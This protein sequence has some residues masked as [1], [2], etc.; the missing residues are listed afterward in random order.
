MK[1]SNKILLGIILALIFIIGCGVVGFVNSKK[2]NTTTANIKQ[3]TKAVAKT[4]TNPKVKAQQKTTKDTTKNDTSDDNFSKTP[5][6]SQS[7]LDFLQ[8]VNDMSSEGARV[9]GEKYAEYL[10]NSNSGG[11]PGNSIFVLENNRSGA[12]DGGVLLTKN[13]D[14]TVT[15]TI[16]D[17]AGSAPI[18]KAV[19]DSKTYKVISQ[20]EIKNNDLKSMWQ[21]FGVKE[22]G[23]SYSNDN[24]SSN[25]NNSDNSQNSDTNQNDDNSDN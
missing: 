15:L 7:A 10:V 4:T 9:V 8:K 17:G 23:V 11:F 21:Y 25:D 20:N 16:G 13:S 2:H 1:R 12:G 3:T 19:V 5:W 6:T 18:E 22:P 24:S 14:N